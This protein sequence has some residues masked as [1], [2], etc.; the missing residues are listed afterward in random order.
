MEHASGRIGVIVGTWA[1]GLLSQSVAAMP[2]LPVVAG[3]N[4]FT[5]VLLVCN[6]DGCRHRFKSYRARP[7]WNNYYSREHP[8]ERVVDPIAEAVVP[9]QPDR[10]RTGAGHR[11]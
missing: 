9:P 6:A 4:D 5:R 3:P 10:S 1:L 7:E 8:A 2:L 11:R